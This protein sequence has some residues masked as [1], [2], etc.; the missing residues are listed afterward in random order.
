MLTT[1]S[2]D[3]LLQLREELEAIKD[4]FSMVEFDEEEVDERKGKSGRGS[5]SGT[6]SSLQLN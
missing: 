3:E 5:K 4:S 6:F 2:G 1:L